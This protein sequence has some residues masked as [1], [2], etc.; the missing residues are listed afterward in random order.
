MQEY[1]EFIKNKTKVIIDSGFDIE[2]GE[3][4]E[5][6]FDYQK[7]IIRWALRKGRCAL[8]EDT[9]LGKTIQQLEWAN[10]VHKHTNKPVLI[11]SPLA[12]AS[13]TE[14]EAQKFGIEAKKIENNSDVINGINIINYEKLHKID[15]DQF[16]G[17]VLD[18][19]SILKAFTGKESM[20][21]IETFRKTPYK[22][23]CSA[24][25]SPNDYTEIGTQAEFLNV[26]EKREML[27]LFFINDAS[28]GIGWRLKGHSEE[29]F[30]KWI[31]NWGIL[32]KNPDNLGFDGSKFILPELNIQSV[33]LDSKVD[34]GYLF[35]VITAKTLSERRAARKESLQDKIEKIKDIINDNQNEKFL[36]WCNYND[37]SEMLKRAI[38]NAYEIKGSDKDEHK[39]YGMIEFAKGNI[40]CLISKPSI[41]GF[42]M[43]WQVCHNIIFCGLSDSFEQFYQ[44]IRRCY[45]FGQTQPVNVYIVMSE[46]ELS[47]LDNIKEKENKHQKMST[48]MINIVSE[49]LKE[50]LQ[51]EKHVDKK[52]EYHQIVRLPD[53]IFKGDKK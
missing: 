8:F 46:K 13:Q 20:L 10:Q 49:K 38:P 51:I 9:G 7:L 29:E 14:L 30:Y 40:D 53:F 32:L 16:I 36:I 45:R 41:C 12:V 21:L 6:L 31:S 37:E 52:D 11:L 24:T 27:S 19:S 28:S 3:L 2:L 34:D 44:A 1:N 42:G 23:S 15:T 22:L 4:N 35:G 18:E 39:S 25:P 5:N 50:D 33:I 43:N 26:C 48:N 47:I 17:V